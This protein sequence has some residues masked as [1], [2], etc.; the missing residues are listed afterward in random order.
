MICPSPPKKDDLHEIDHQLELVIGSAWATN[1]LATRNSQWSRYLRFCYD[2]SLTP[3]PAHV[4][5]IARFL[6]HLG[7]TC[8]YSTC[9]NYLSAVISLHKFMGHHQNFRDC[10]IIKLVLMG[11]GR[12]LGKNVQQKIGI[13]PSQFLQMYSKIN[14]KDVNVLTKWAALILSF[15]SLL[16]K[17]NLVPTKQGDNDA[18]ILRSDVEFTASGIVL[19][20]RK[21]K[22][23]QRKEYVLRIP[24]LYNNSPCFC[25][26]SMLAAHL[27]RSADSTDGPLFLM[28]RS[29]TWK[30]LL[31]KELLGFL[32][33]CVA[34]IGLNPSDAGLH[35][36]R[37]SGASYLHSIGV[38][39]V[40]IMRAGDWRSL[41]ALEYLVCPFERK[42]DIEGKAS[43]T[44]TTFSI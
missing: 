12:R 35:S 29:G 33:E 20:V 23:L 30:P 3:M 10:Y 26:A 31:Y 19:H 11:L 9:N 39:L 2:R 5:T 15:R 16:R 37:R 17:S 42:L 8:V 44:L 18:L 38:S 1:T 14:L 21:T 28:Y 32:K 40:D 25:A 41:A 24:V 6:V 43:M 36:M 34:N 27:A 4:L 13:T 7:S 22:T